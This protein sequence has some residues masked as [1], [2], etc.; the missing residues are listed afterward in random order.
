MPMR[1][2]LGLVFVLLFPASL[3]FATYDNFQAEYEKVI[4]LP[5]CNASNSEVK[6]IQSDADW[7]EINNTKFRVFCVRPGDYSGAGLITITESGTSTSNRYL[8]LSK[9]NDTG[10]MPWEVASNER[11]TLAAILFNGAGHW[12][13]DRLAVTNPNN[14]LAGNKLLDVKSKSHDLIFNGLLL[15]KNNDILFRIT[16]GGKDITLQNSVLRDPKLINNKANSCIYIAIRDSDGP[17]I[18]SRI[19]NNEIYNC[20][21]DGIQINSNTKKT[22]PAHGLDGIIVENNDI[23]I[24]HD[25]YT[26]GKG[27]FNTKGPYSC[28]ENAIDIKITHVKSAEDIA[29]FLHN[30]IWGFR[31]VEPDTGL[32][33]QNGSPTAPAIAIHHTYADYILVKDNIITDSENGIY[34]AKSGPNNISLIGNLLYDVANK[35]K[36]RAALVLQHGSK[37]EAYNNAVV[38]SGSYLEGGASKVDMRNNIFI[39][40]GNWRQKDIS[41][42]SHVKHNAFFNTVTYDGSAN[43]GNNMEKGTASAAGN[44]EFC[45]KRKLLT[46]PERICIPHVIASSGSPY[47]DNFDGAAG[48]LSGYGIDDQT[49]SYDP[50][51]K[52]ESQSGVSTPAGVELKRD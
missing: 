15:E 3:S 4:S 20:P 26:D 31:T 36:K 5:D 2:H 49:V 42:D 46:N 6:I 32:C 41:S 8:I 43:K 34:I 38:A 37:I 23:Y 33:D 25:M 28:A 22:A 27:N 47:L 21:E 40:S 17:T 16:E 39:N 30:R 19:V 45:F 29:Q 50:V 24:T 9:E 14:K 51:W 48:A 35:T 52:N 44:S 10:K 13:V 11:A 1:Y 18:R 12:V 7:K